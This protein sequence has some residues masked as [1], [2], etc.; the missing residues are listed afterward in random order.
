L[1]RESD[2]V[3][4]KW[5]LLSPKSPQPARAANSL[6]LLNAARTQPN[7]QTEQTEGKEEEEEEGGGGN[8]LGQSNN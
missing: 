6:A 3:G 1:D 2:D 4:K 5:T 7:K 8:K